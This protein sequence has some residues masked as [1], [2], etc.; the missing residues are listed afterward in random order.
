MTDPQLVYIL[1]GGQGVVYEVRALDTCGQEQVFAAKFELPK[2]DGTFR[3]D[4]MQEVSAWTGAQSKLLVDEM[5]CTSVHITDSSSSCLQRTHGK[6][7]WTMHVCKCSYLELLFSFANLAR[8]SRT[9]VLSRIT[10]IL[11]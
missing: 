5:Q 1:Q 11:S 2:E 9:Q 8:L 4:L 6:D 7:S 10:R 3:G